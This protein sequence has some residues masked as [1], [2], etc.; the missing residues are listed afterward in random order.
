MK[1]FE[2]VMTIRKRIDGFRFEFGS[3]GAGGWL[4]PGAAVPRPEE[5]TL[6]LWIEEADGAFYLKW[7]SSNSHYVSSDS[8]HKTL[9]EAV[10][11]AKHS[12]GVDPKDWRDP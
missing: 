6:N 7:V 8:W 2:I 5:T 3:G 4:P 11:Q 12:F 1:S 10:E 9:D